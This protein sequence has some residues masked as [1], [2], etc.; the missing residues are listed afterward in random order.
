[1]VDRTLPAFPLGQ[2]DGVEPSFGITTRQY[3]I[4]A[5]I[6]GILAGDVNLRSPVDGVAN[7]AI[8]VA[9]AVLARED[10]DA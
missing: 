2:M 9:D 8:A 5:A 10:V 1:M 3:Y 4:A 7:H 6:T